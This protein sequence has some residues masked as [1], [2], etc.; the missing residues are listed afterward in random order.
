MPD[1]FAFSVTLWLCGQT[2]A[3]FDLSE[4]SL[5]ALASKAS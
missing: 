5:F 2:K 3:S 4:A 1:G